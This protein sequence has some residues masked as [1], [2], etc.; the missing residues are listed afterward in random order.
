MKNVTGKIIGFV[1]GTAG[2]LFLFRVIV[3]DQHSPEDE[4][5][6]GIVVFTALLSGLLFAFL[7]HLI[8]N[9]F[10]KKRG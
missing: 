10:I 6:P 1:L 2:F 5:A 4:L 3:L 7:G 8:Q 9:A